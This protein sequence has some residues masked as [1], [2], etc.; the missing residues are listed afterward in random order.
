MD[1]YS[2]GGAVRD[3]LLGY[4]VKDRDWVVVGA[5]AQQLLEQGFQQ[6]GKDFPVFLHP[7]SKEEYAL[8]RTERKLGHGYTGFNCYAAS[9]VT[10]EQDLLRR[11]LTI[12]AMAED[13]DGQ[14]YD[15]YHGRDDLDK[16]L[17][18]HVSPAF[19]EDPLRVL[20]IARFHARYAHL[21]FKVA[22]ETMLLM[23]EMVAQG[24]LEH[25]VKERIWQESSRALLEK[26]PSIY[27]ETL[28]ECGALAVIMPELDALFGIPQPPQHHPEIDC[29]IHSLMVLQQAAKMSEELSVRFAAL[30]HDLGKA[31]TPEQK[32]PQHIQH[33]TLAK[34]P[35]QALC[36]R[37]GAPNE[38]REL[39]LI[40]AEQHTNIH[41]THE[42]RANTVVKILEK[43]DAFRRRE[44][45]HQL[46]VVCEADARGRL[47][48]E[49]KN[50]PQRQLFSTLLTACAQVN[51]RPFVE[52]GL[53]GQEIAVAVRKARVEA[54]KQ[55][56]QT[57]D[58][59]GS[60]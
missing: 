26:T 58:E 42:L 59:N 48:F 27:F 60:C 43:T 28:R 4:P 16:R 35:I 45:F 56:Q 44:R 13:A 49:D 10:L 34:A 20:R 22:D 29:G 17:L 51:P 40:A 36:Q 57:L 39:A 38:C 19:A 47:G 52:A 14:I 32:W 46:L 12:N 53:K 50:Y 37:L 7:E 1:I 23:R 9:D 41:R 3:K 21:N 6:V 54:V 15:P 25:L 5:T 31:L 24:E 55:L 18:R 11:D 30:C 8:A 2:V 33:E